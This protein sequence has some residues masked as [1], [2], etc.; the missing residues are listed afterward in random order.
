MRSMQERSGEPW[1]HEMV[2][3]VDQPNNLL[4]L[5]FVREAWGIAQDL[6]IPELAPM[7]AVGD[8]ARPEI[9]APD[10]WAER[11]ADAWHAAW[12]WYAEGAAA[13]YLHVAGSDHR[14]AR[15]AV[16][17][18]LP[19]MWESHFGSTGID[20]E[21]L[22]Q[23]TLA[24]QDEP[25]TL[26]EAPERRSLSDLVAAWRDGIDSIVVLPYGIDFSHRITTRHLVVSSTT[27]DDPA[28]YGQALQRA[29]GASPSLG[30]P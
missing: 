9:P 25:V 14:A 2:I 12:A 16:D 17:P 1:P 20:R 30:T 29:V 21:A 7:P 15:A 8:S 23:W 5:L 3:R 28:L 22:W 11:W 27:R 4:T 6:D 19:P 24:I 13:H 10:V 26:D 18:S